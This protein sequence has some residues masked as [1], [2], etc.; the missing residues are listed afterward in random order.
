MNIDKTIFLEIYM[1]LSLILC[2]NYQTLHELT[3]NRWHNAMAVMWGVIAIIAG[4]YMVLEMTKDG[5]SKRG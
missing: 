5:R 4:T 1:L 3:N 2:S